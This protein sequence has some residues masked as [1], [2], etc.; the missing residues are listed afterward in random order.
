[1]ATL[2]AT[3]GASFTPTGTAFRVKSTGGASSLLSKSDVDD[4]AWAFVG[5]IPSGRDM[6]VSNAV[7]GTIY[8]I[9]AGS[10]AVIRAWE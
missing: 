7:A 4:P 8:R 2:T 10:T 3:S 5:E 1:M 9:D 6:A